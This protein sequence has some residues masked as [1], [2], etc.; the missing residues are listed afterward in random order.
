MITYLMKN[1]A[2][3]ETVAVHDDTILRYMQPSTLTEQ[4]YA[5]DNIAKLC[6]VADV[7]D[8]STVNDVF[9]ESVDSSIQHSF[10]SYCATHSQADLTD[11]VFH[12]KS[13]L[14]I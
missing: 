6:K 4:Q 7:Y 3:D 11:I 9:I 14:V 8:K 1:F 12:T 2:T 13:F 5:G 10:S